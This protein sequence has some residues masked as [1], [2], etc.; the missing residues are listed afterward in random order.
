MSTI[1]FNTSLYGY[2]KNYSHL[3]KIQ[4][5]F[6]KS[7]FDVLRRKT[8]TFYPCFQRV[9]ETSTAPEYDETLTLCFTNDLK[10]FLLKEIQ[11]CL[12]NIDTKQLEI[13]T[14]SSHT[15][16]ANIIRNNPRR[17]HSQTTTLSNNETS[18][19]WDINPYTRPLVT[20]CYISDTTST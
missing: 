12:G 5:F 7:V 6:L 19:V 16:G 1:S 11:F 10:L 15:V 4:D 18:V 13:S 2:F 20:L 3:E 9:F 17:L 8:Y 14:L